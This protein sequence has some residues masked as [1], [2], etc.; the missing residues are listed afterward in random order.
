[1]YYQEWESLEQIYLSSNELESIDLLDKFENLRII[2]ASSNSIS[3]VNMRL[4]NLE[5]MLLKD[6]N[7]KQ[8][9]VLTD[10][11]KLIVLNLQSNK[12]KDLKNVDPELT[13]NI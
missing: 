1:M 2:D 7:L 10:M 11:Q 3:E 8:F 6:N 5:S 4:P 9:P 12:I 13:P